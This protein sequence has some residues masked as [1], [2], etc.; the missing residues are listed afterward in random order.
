MRQQ[1]YQQLDLEIIEARVKRRHD[2]KAALTQG[3]F[4]C[5]EVASI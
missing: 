2:A 4:E 5:V 1:S 3:S